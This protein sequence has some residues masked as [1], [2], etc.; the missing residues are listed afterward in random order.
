[1]IYLFYV[2]SQNSK[3]KKILRTVFVVIF[4]KF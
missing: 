1:M 2:S 3:A 4:N